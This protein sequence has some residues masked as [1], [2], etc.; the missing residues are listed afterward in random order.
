MSASCHFQRSV[1]INAARK[2]VNSRVGGDNT[3][4]PAYICPVV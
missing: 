4:E 1:L 2:S 3:A